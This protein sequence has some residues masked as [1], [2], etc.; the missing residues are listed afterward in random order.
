MTQPQDRHALALSPLQVGPLTF[1][2][3]IFVPAH[4]TNFGDDH[5][6]SQRHLDY[7]LARARGGVGAIVFESIRVHLNSVGRP[8]AV[9]GFDES[10]IAPFA[11]I[12]SAVKAEG[13][14]ILGQI[15][16]LGR[17]VEGDFER[18]VSWG[19]SPVAWSATG[20]PPRQMDEDDMAEVID[21]HVRSARNL[22]EAGF[23]GIELQMAHGH[24]LQQFISPLSNHRTDAYGGSLDNRLRFPIAVLQAVR[25]ALGDGFCLG[26]RFGAEEYVPG[27]L[28]IDEAEI[29]VTRLAAASR[30]DFVNVSH[31]AYHASH[32]LATQM[33][34]MAMDPTPFRAL[35]ARVRT[36]LRAAGDP[37]PV[38]A[39]CRFTTL[40]QAET[41]LRDGIADAVG[42]AR[43]HI[44]DPALVAKTRAGRRS[45]IRACIACNQGCA[46]MLERN[47]PIRCMVNP[48]AGM[49]GV[50]PEPAAAP[51]PAPRKVLVIG[52]GPAGMEAATTAAAL[53]HAVSLW[54]AEPHLG[55]RLIWTRS[56]P[57]RAGFA[58]MLDRQACALHRAGV[59]IRRN[60]R[61]D[62]DA[63][64]AFGADAIL[65]ATGAAPAVP[66]LP[67]GGALRSLT[68]ALA[69][70]AALGPRVAVADFT[71]DWP[72]LSVVERLADL[73]LDVT[74]LT[75]PAAFA[76]RTTIYST[77]ATS[78]RLRA[79]AV[80]VRP[81]RRPVRWDGATLTVE[82][83]SSGET[84]DMTGLSA[85]I[86]ADHDRAAPG[87]W[88]E[89]RARGLPARRIGDANAPRTALEA[90]YSGHQA[91]REI[92]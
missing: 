76:W 52:G 89:L 55:G 11:R 75:P 47:L 3:R 5:L 31:S 49:E 90:I 16:H 56:M 86:V 13:A 61:A 44:A 88:P 62:I 41:A 7:H 68:Q 18:T 30:L 45:D 84:E 54:E 39:V 66:S 34:D 59:D 15:I 22:V 19:A 72:A 2:N 43:A 65:L 73:G 33:A 1:R 71:G 40:D 69:D 35:P 24:L 8:Q 21:G 53:G 10:C 9:Q 42:M 81:L 80:R 23:E 48:M 25:A 78:A 17:Q 27:G 57:K 4:T 58:E 14:R 92:A 28:T 20:L 46:G 82:D 87:L 26:I 50:W 74:V 6:P 91:A 63:I 12:T 32:S 77:L 64:E 36:A 67:G 37:A 51:A 38:F 83:L 70:P 85:V 60:T 79:R 29:A